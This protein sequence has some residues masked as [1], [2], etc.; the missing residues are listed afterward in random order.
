VTGVQTCALPIFTGFVLDGSTLVRH[1]WA[2][3][4]TGA[5][6][7]PVDPSSGDAPAPPDLFALAVHD[8]SAEALAGAEAAFAPLRRASVSWLP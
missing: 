8:T 1:R 3:V 5:R 7:L 6:W 4:W 2:V